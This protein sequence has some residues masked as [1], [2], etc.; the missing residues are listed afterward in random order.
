MALQQRCA[1]LEPAIAEG[2]TWRELL[3]LSLAARLASLIGAHRDCRDLSEQLATLD[4]RPV[5]LRVTELLEGRRDRELHRDIAGAA[6]GAMGAFL[7]IV[8]GSALWIASGWQDG[9]T[10]VMLAGVFLA[11]FA[12]SDDPLVPL[13][14]F[15]F[16]TLAAALLGA[17]YGYAILPRLDGFGLLAAIR[18]DGLSVLA[19]DIMMR[20]PDD[21]ARLAGEVMRL[22]ADI[23]PTMERRAP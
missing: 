20:D 14:A 5:S 3:Q 13:R 11:L 2:S 7:T 19:T 8:I 6:R 12:A 23:S 15:F 18:A 4:R 21:A 10:A 16:G 1:G 17:V 9:S 22:V